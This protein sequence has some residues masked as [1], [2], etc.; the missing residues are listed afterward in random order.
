[1]N[2][3]LRTCST[4]QTIG[5]YLPFLV[6]LLSALV[7][8]AVTW[9]VTGNYV[10]SDS[11]SELVL[12]E[13]LAETRQI[14]S[15]DW[16]YSTELRVFQHQLVYAP[17][18][19][20]LNDWHLVRFLGAMILQTGYILSFAYMS[21]QA[22][23]RRETFWYG[24]SLL[25]LPVNVAYGRIILYHTY[26][27][28]YITMSFLMFGLVIHLYQTWNPRRLRSWLLTGVLMAVSFLSGTNS[29]RQLMITHAP[30]LFSIVVLSVRQDTADSRTA[31]ILSKNT[32]RF[33]AFALLAAAC[34][35]AALKFNELYLHKHYVDAP[36][37]SDTVNLMD[38]AVLDEMLFGYLHQF[39]MRRSVPLVSVFG[40][41]SVGSVVA[42]G[43]ALYVSAKALL[44]SKSLN[45]RSLILFGHCSFT[46]VMMAVF[47]FTAHKGYYF[48]LYFTMAWPWAVIPLVESW[49]DNPKKYS[50]LHRNRII[51]TAAALVLLLSGWLN[52]AWFTRVISAEQ[53]YEGLAYRDRDTKDELSGVTAYLL[54]N[55][56]EIGY[57][58]YWNAN[59]LTEITNGSVRMIGLEDY[60]NPKDGVRYYDF[61][62]SLWLREIPNEKPFLLVSYDTFELEWL[63]PE[64]MEPYTELVYADEL[65]KI[66]D[67][68][69]FESF[70]ELL[71]S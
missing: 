1:M 35:F 58:T 6:F 33:L 28:L 2:K 34:S 61:L 42:G 21:R 5:H 68:T 27:I 57:A 30:M 16:F 24:A 50:P 11:A 62:T 64:E 49:G 37:Y 45:P 38:F 26:Y 9:Y 29:I 19:L 8:I 14:M 39:G 23:F 70:R 40:I 47:L 10:D 36:Y 46:T 41:L 20:F 63:F 52:V 17:L 53:R 67:V 43:Y 56:Y 51:A 3:K 66:Y 60:G 55:G 32:L 4:S 54:E 18:M 22:G 69:D 65:Y 44:Q 31:T 12:A 59:V 15:Q 25:L 71:Y 48:P 7:S 13:H